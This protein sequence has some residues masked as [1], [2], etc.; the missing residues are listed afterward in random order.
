M[1]KL[2]SKTTK[3]AKKRDTLSYR[4]WAARGDLLAP[5]TWK[6]SRIQIDRE[7]DLFNIAHDNAEIDE[8]FGAVLACHMLENVSPHTFY[9]ATEHH[10]RMLDYFSAD[11]SALVKRWAE[12]LD[13]KCIMD[14]EDIFFS[15]YVESHTAHSWGP[16][17]LAPVGQKSRPYHYLDG[18]FPLPNLAIGVRTPDQ[19]AVESRLPVLVKVPAAQKFAVA[20][21]LLEAIDLSIFLYTG[22][23]EPPYDDKIDFVVAGGDVG[24]FEMPAKRLELGWLRALREQCAKVG[25]PLVITRLGRR[26]WGEWGKNP[27]KRNDRE[28]R[29][30]EY[31]LKSRDGLDPA[32]WPADLKPRQV[33]PSIVTA[34][35][36][37]AAAN[38]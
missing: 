5:L 6:A 16:G 32:E 29:V 14:N 10:H 12:A 9:L 24:T 2:I 37:R 18:I 13:G 19:A 36:R 15:E 28:G 35:A 1:T 3:T 20:E 23:T 26:P 33:E 21:P 38:E 25:A 4:T 8:V 27:P 7:T 34:P 31:V 11:K 30:G 17:G 22:W